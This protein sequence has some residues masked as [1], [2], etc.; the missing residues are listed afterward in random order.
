VALQDVVGNAHHR[1]PWGATTVLILQQ[2]HGASQVPFSSI[3]V[4]E[5]GFIS[6]Y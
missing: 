2:G 5:N 4:L 1:R 6:N 3:Q